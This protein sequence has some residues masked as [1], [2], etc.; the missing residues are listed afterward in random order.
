MS[1]A[2]RSKLGQRLAP[3]GLGAASDKVKMLSM[4]AI[5]KEFTQ[6]SP[7]LASGVS[8]GK[9]LHLDVQPGKEGHLHAG[10][11]ESGLAGSLPRFSRAWLACQTLLGVKNVNV[12]SK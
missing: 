6:I 8:P 1:F 3:E 12:A 4:C 2:M 11:P 9:P 7:H 5:H 10:S